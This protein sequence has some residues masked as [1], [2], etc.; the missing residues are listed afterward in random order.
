[1]QAKVFI[2]FE[3]LLCVRANDEVYLLLSICVIFHRCIQEK[4]LKKIDGI[5]LVMLHKL[6]QTVGKHIFFQLKCVGHS[7]ILVPAR[8]SANGSINSSIH[9]FI[10]SFIH[11]FFYSFIHLCIH[12]F[13]H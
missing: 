3:F 10:H 2:P 8:Y 9:P 5:H 11:S 4:V 1:M 12:S 6:Y 13:I 7:F